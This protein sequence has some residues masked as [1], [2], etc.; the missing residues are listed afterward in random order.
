MR[1]GPLVIAVLGLGCTSSAPESTENGAKDGTP[2]AE[3][4]P[5]AEATPEP[6]PAAP[7]PGPAAP[8]P[9]PATSEPAASPVD[10]ADRADDSPPFVERIT[11][12]TGEAEKLTIFVREASLWVTDGTRS[13]P[14]REMAT[15]LHSVKLGTDSDG[16][17]TLVVEY[18]DDISCDAGRRTET[19]AAHTLLARLENAGAMKPHRAGNHEESAAGFAKAAA[20]DPM[21]DIAWT[22]LACAEA[23]RGN[24]AEAVAALR[25]PLERR[26]IHALF[27]VMTDS[28]L[29]SIRG[30]A[31]ITTR[32]APTPGTVE[33]R[34]MTMAYSSHLGMVALLRHE[35]SWGSCTFRED[36]EIYDV[37][38]GDRVETLLLIDWEH[39]DPSCEP[40]GKIVPKHRK[41][42]EA[43]R[44][45]MQALLRG[46]GFS[47]SPELEVVRA[48][49]A[50]T[51][52]ARAKARFPRAGLGLAIGSGRARLLRGSE[53]LGTSGGE[54]Y[55]EYV[56]GFG[57]AGYD[58]RAGVAFVEW[59]QETAEGCFDGRQAVGYS[60]IVD[61]SSAAAP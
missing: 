61:G 1:I 7:E 52:T 59:H 47:V 26:P 20:L 29:S 10:P 37:K 33:L 55:T 8:E 11:V 15:E 32:L 38:T 51:G 30:E 54:A 23:L 2:G 28:E 50:E 49:E 44:D 36:V 34:D 43:R 6:G 46:L 5:I 22:N 18:T 42:V 39:T 56:R 60:I 3:P 35:D 4:A 12:E 16:K 13:A 19:L 27:K 58:P 17:P 53:V 57:R 45:G 25:L 21:L 31:Q 40:E 14:L 41:T 9:G 24:T 48:T